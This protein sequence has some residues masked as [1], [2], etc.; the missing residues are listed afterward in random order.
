MPDC[1]LLA[2]TRTKKSTTGSSSC[3]R[4]FSFQ[5]LGKD[6]RCRRPRKERYLFKSRSRRLNAAAPNIMQWVGQTVRGKA[7]PHICR[8]HWRLLPPPSRHP[9][10][11]VP[12]EPD[13]IIRIHGQRRAVGGDLSLC[14]EPD[15]ATAGQQAYC[16]SR[17]ARHVMGRRGAAPDPRH[18]LDL[19]P[20]PGRPLDEFLTGTR[21]GLGR[22]PLTNADFGSRHCFG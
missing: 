17:R 13:V 6:G 16:V 21:P 22:W 3:R 18:F 2:S 5:E 4:K 9:T 19:A 8:P 12:P 15:V 20:P 14:A 7:T 10:F 11:S 1:V